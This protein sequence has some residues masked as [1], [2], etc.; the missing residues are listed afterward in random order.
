[1]GVFLSSITSGIFGVG[2]MVVF[3]NIP[4]SAF[5]AVFFGWVF[6]DIIVLAT[7]GTLLMVVF[8]PYIVRSRFYVKRYFS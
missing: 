8:T 7:L 5:G 3:G 4:V 6:G 2:A 1:M